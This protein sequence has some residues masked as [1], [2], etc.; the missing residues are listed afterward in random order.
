MPRSSSHNESNL[1]PTGY[2]PW[3]ERPLL[4]LKVASEIAGVSPAS[5]YRFSDEGKLKLRE[6][7]GRTLV[8][9]QSLIAL[10]ETAKDWSPRK[11]GAEAR[12]KRKDAARA[13]LV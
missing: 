6:L 1:H 2:T 10:I 13:A 12:A 3:R 11:C 7:G 8:D 5:L 9:T 4:P